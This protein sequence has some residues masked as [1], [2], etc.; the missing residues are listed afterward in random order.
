MAPY[1]G[2]C[3]FIF[4]NGRESRQEPRAKSILPNRRDLMQ[5]KSHVRAVSECVLGR[6]QLTSH[7]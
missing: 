4:M 1:N 2:M 3:R 5:A 6:K 7:T